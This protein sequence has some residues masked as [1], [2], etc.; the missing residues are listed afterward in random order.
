MNPNPSIS[1]APTVVEIYVSTASA[2]NLRVE[3]DCGSRA[4]VLI[5]SG[6]TNSEV[7]GA[8]VRLRSEY[9]N[10]AL[11]RITVTESDHAAFVGKLK[12]LG[13]VLEQITMRAAFQRVERPYNVALA[14]VA[15]WLD[16]VCRLCNGLRFDR[17]PGTPSLSNRGCKVCSGTGVNKIPYGDAGKQLHSYMLDC[18]NRW[19]SATGKR[20]RGKADL[21]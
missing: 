15:C 10:A 11:P 12:S 16:C 14:V 19:K 7:G 21:N 1:A 17:I 2:S 6:W 8:L 18:L 13:L 5:A 20:L 9:D 3:A 4:D